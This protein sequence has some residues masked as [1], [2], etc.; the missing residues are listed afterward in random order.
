MATDGDQAADPRLR[1][2][3]PPA[4]AHTRAELTAYLDATADPALAGS[5]SLKG[6]P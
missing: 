2:P 3:W 1:G 4:T 6:C 5:Q